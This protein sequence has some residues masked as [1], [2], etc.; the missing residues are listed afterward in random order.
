MTTK[1]RFIGETEKKEI[2]AMYDAGHTLTEIV[3][4]TGRHHSA[5]SKALRSADLKR[6]FK[7][8]DRVVFT[9]DEMR[10]M[11]DL[12]SK[13]LCSQDIAAQMPGR[14]K[15]TIN[16]KL[17]ALGYDRSLRV[18]N[19][20]REIILRLKDE[21]H[22]IREIAD[23]VGV[24]KSTVAGIHSLEDLP[25]VDASGL[26]RVVEG[27]ICRIATSSGKYEILVDAADYA[28]LPQ[29]SIYRGPNG[30]AM[31]RVNGV[32]TYL[33]H[34]IMG[35]PPV[36]K[37]VD[38]INGNRFDCRRSNL[39]FASHSQNSQNAHKRGVGEAGYLGIKK[40]AK[41]YVA[42]VSL[43]LGTF[44]TPEEAARAYDTKAAELFGDFAMTNKKRGLV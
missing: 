10:L 25:R 11:C 2:A 28:L 41:G 17:Q 24:G 23:I 32:T 6:P 34:I 39:R 37:V 42:T 33:H 27:D 19:E 38:H 43:N 20:K 9:P 35:K 16:G 26:R 4:M 14:R 29:T 8:R 7:S 3:E 30:Y 40:T 21:G 18:S 22:T 31:C 36:G 12:A 15:E 44:D 5:V 13:G 1:T